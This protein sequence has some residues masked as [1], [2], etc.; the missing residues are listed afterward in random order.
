MLYLIGLGLNEKGISLEGRE[1]LKD[2]SK[3]Y[4]EGYTV[5]FPYTLEQLEKTL[6]TKIINLGRKEVESDFLVKEA[7]K[8]NMALLVYGCPLFATTH[9]TLL[10]DCKKAKVKTKII[11][12]A[13]VFDA[14]AETGLQLYKFGKITSMPKWQK[15]FTPDS[16]MDIVR[17]NNS[18]KAHS[19]ILIDIGLEFSKA[20][21]E[22]KQASENKKIKLEKIV[23]CS[24]LGTSKSKIFYDFIDKIPEKQIK[25]PFCII[26]PSEM[27]FMEE[28][29]LNNS[30][31]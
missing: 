22:L 25:M 15:S 14:I 28:Q 29:S 8:E 26:L 6:S 11:Y 18:I 1:S 9:T 24:S 5:D 7:K 13:S 30:K 17:E 12:S 31:Q 3:V 23:V 27:H 20:L 21:D 10:E 4:L 19:L 2:C 16:F